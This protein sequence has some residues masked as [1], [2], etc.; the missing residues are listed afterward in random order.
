MTLKELKEEFDKE[1]DVD[2]SKRTNKR[3]YANAK[4]AFA[5]VANYFYKDIADIAE[6]LNVSRATVSNML[7][8]SHIL[9]EK[10]LRTVSKMKAKF[11]DNEIFTTLNGHKIEGNALNSLMIEL[12]TWEEHK[13]I[14]LIET[15]VKPFKRENYL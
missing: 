3:V 14:E 2:I 15:K 4:K 1:Y 8:Q 6:V 13:I 7:Y 5:I 12:S 11:R 10:D 9:R